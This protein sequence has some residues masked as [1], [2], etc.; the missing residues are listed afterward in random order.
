MMMAG[1][2]KF[3]VITEYGLKATESSATQTQLNGR[4]YHDHDDH[5]GTA[6]NISMSADVPADGYAIAISYTN[7]NPDA[8]AWSAGVDEEFVSSVNIS[9]NQR[10]VEFGARYYAAESLAQSFA[11][12]GGSSATRRAGVVT[13]GPP[14]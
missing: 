2:I 9:G 5:D 13:F 14:A 7:S 11:T 3:P 10:S 12:S 4:V 8:A 6:S 1:G